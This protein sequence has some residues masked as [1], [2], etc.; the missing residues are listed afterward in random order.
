MK[1]TVIALGAA[2]VVLAGATFVT[3]QAVRDDESQRARVGQVAQDPQQPG[4]PGSRQ[5]M[6]M[7]PGR[8]PRGQGGPMMGP[9]RGG[10]MTG[11]G[12]GAGL[13]A[14]NLSEEQRA[15][16]DELHRTA[17]DQ[18]APIADELALARKTLHREVFAE[19]RDEAKVASLAAKVATLQ[20]Q[21]ADLHL[22]T[23][24][25]VA[26]ELSADQRETMRL[27]DGAGFGGRGRGP[28]R[29][30]FGRGRF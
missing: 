16:I 9:G 20:K 26:G 5:R 6:G 24:L 28:G 17:R 10:P 15:K 21:L 22:K 12:G 8:G 27:H 7:G 29:P 3:A 18:S 11:R 4:P 25:A 1:H 30:G 13:A 2:A 19:K 23:S 14:L